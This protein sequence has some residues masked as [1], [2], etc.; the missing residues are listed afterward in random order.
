MVNEKYQRLANLKF[1]SKVTE[2]ATW[3]EKYLI[4]WHEIGYDGWKMSLFHGLVVMNNLALTLFEMFFSKIWF[5]FFNRKI[6][7][8]REEPNSNKLKMWP[9]IWKSDVWVW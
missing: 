2:K 1:H 9:I 4:H 8:M 5:F 7:H 6:N 3:H